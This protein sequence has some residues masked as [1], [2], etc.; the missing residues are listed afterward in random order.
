[1]FV[2]HYHRWLLASPEGVRDW[3]GEGPIVLEAASRHMVVVH[4]VCCGRCALFDTVTNELLPLDLERE[5][6][7]VR[8]RDIEH[9]R[10][11]DS[12][13]AGR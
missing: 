1:M 9:R 11:P 8:H 12:R 7:G 10:L 3:S 5:G 13:G 6:W 4:A 2:G